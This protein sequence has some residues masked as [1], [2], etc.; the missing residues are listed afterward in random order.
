MPS[1][2]PEG[3]SGNIESLFG[4]KRFT[5]RWIELADFGGRGS[6][7]VLS[8]PLRLLGYLTQP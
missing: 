4:I 2:H 6:E 5:A 8:D 1:G 7:S 3:C